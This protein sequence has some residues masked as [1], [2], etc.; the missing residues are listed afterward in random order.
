MTHKNRTIPKQISRVDVIDE[1][2]REIAKTI[3]T[4]MPDH[5]KNVTQSS[6]LWNLGKI[7]MVL[8]LNIFFP[9][10]TAIQSLNLKSMMAINVISSLRCE[11]IQGKKKN[12]MSVSRILHKGP[13]FLKKE[14]LS[15]R[16]AEISHILKKRASEVSGIH[17]R[18]ADT[19]VYDGVR[20]NFLRLLS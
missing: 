3:R 18:E 9:L 12:I 14:H 11:K 7:S 16:E 6:R 8:N 5:S 10:S 20:L 4:E 2:G 1:I 19:G 13:Y 17:L 15:R